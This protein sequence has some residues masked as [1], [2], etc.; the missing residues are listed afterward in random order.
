[1]EKTLIATVL[2]FDKQLTGSSVKAFVEGSYCNT[3]LKVFHPPS[4]TI[5]VFSAMCSTC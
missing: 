2:D 5:N 1:M 4:T 3:S